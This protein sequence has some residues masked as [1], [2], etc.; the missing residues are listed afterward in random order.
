MAKPRRVQKQELEANPLLEALIACAKA[1]GEPAITVD[2][3]TWVLQPLIDITHTLAPEERREF[4]EDYAAADK[5]KSMTVE[6]A[7]AFY[8]ETLKTRG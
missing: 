8:K 3:Q 2:G 6:K 7:M 1:G 5:E 4:A